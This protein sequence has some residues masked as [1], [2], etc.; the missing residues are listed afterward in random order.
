MKRICFDVDGIIFD[1]DN[2]INMSIVNMIKQLKTQEYKI[3]L[4]THAEISEY[5][6]LQDALEYFEV[7]YD[8]IYF[9][10]PKADIFIDDQAVNISIKEIENIIIFKNTLN[11][12]LGDL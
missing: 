3:I 7:V 10:K 2:K 1:K 11:H 5:E 12:Y 6:R 8:E 4:Y 9:G